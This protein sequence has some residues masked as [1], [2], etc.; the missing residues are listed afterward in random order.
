MSNGIEVAPRPAGYKPPTFREVSSLLEELRQSRS[1]KFSEI[2]ELKRAREDNWDNLLKEIPASFRKMAPMMG[3]PDLAEM[4]DRIAGLITRNDPVIEVI[5]PSGR[6]EDIR[7]AAAEEA[8]LHAL[9]VSAEDQQARPIYQLGVHSLVNLGESWITVLPDPSRIPYPDDDEEGEADGKDA[10]RGKDEDAGEYVKRIK[11]MQAD[12]CL[13][14]A[15]E[16][17]D[18]QTAFPLMSRNRLAVMIFETEHTLYDIKLGLGYNPIRK[19]DGKVASWA[20]GGGTLSEGYVPEGEDDG[21]HIVDTTH[22][23]QEVGGTNRGGGERVR[24]IVY[25]DCW[26]VQ[27]F[28]DGVL[29]ERWEHNYGFV[30]CF[31]ASAG[32]SGVNEPGGGSRAVISGALGIARQL[33]VWAAMLT[34]NA[35]LHAYPTPFLRN[36]EHGIAAWNTREPSARTVRLGELNFLG[37]NEEIDF[38]YLK[39]QMGGDFYRNLDFLVKRFEGI[40]LNSWGANLSPE[41]S[42]YAIAQVRALQS[43]VLGPVYQGTAAQWRRAF[44]CARHIIKTE[45]P[46]GVH[47]RGAVEMEE[48]DGEEYAFAPVMT[49]AEDDVTDF[50][51]NVRIDEGII[52]DEL[53][54]RKSA[55][56]MHQAGAW[57]MRRVREETGVEDPAREDEE[58]N[59]ERLMNSPAMDQQIVTGAMAMVA[60]R[61][62]M[63][64]QKTP[65]MQA[66]EQAKQQVL[67]VA[68]GDGQFA[69][70]GAQPVNAAPGG[71]PIQ[72][73]PPMK[74][75][76]QGGPMGGAPPL[77]QLGVPG[78]PGGVQ[79]GNP[80]P[81][82]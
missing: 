7:K 22:D 63:M 20:K 69:N 11:K 44:A 55:L 66:L 81:G 73:N 80:P 43:S 58:V 45:Y 71:Q 9:R 36:P 17:H 82:V 79:G 53:A 24:K 31:G 42:G 39:A 10:R 47:L 61:I 49:Y 48:K 68:A 15:F 51:I 54:M 65:F 62:T 75:P 29:V 57:S 56:E 70:Q 19:A 21:S 38:P 32:Q 77:E 3:F 8:R 50:T 4:G 25:M 2:A 41:T 12:G 46:E 40:S 34:A 72:Q 76:Q 5:P 28:L 14:I 52:Q 1:K 6:Q 35:K 26:A 16:D 30:P 78:I 64:G 13:P 18:P 59:I 33:V 37:P 27:T 67:G 23:N 60:Q 74:Q